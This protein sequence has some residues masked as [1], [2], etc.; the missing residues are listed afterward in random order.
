MAEKTSEQLWKE[1]DAAREALNLTLE[2]YRVRPWDS[3]LRKK[4]V[5]LLYSC[6]LGAHPIAATVIEHRMPFI[7]NDIV[8]EKLLKR[9][10]L[11]ALGLLAA[12]QKR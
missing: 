3:E 10:L 12:I 6:A 9:A 1:Y 11:A 2:V 8:D 7:T 4:V 5:E